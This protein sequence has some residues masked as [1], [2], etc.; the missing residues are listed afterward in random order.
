MIGRGTAAAG[1]DGAARLTVRLTATVARK[2]AQQRALLV[3]LELV[4]TD[5][6]GNV[7]RTSRTLALRR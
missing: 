6:A 5:A 3:R 2:A 1:P 4:A 7:A